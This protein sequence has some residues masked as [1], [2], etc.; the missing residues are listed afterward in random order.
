[1][2]NTVFFHRA[3]D[4]NSLEIDF[5]AFDVGT[6]KLALSSS[7]GNGLGYIS[8]FMTSELGGKIESAKPLVDYLLTLERNGEKLM[9]NETLDTVAKLQEA[10]VIAEVFVSAMPKDTPYQNLEQK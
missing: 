10:L 3:N 1:M 8:K 6:P 5:G 4:E 2:T 7:I 9:I